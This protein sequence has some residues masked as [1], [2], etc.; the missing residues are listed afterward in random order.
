M[1]INQK[2]FKDCLDGSNHFLEKISKRTSEDQTHSIHLTALDT[3]DYDISYFKGL[4]LED[5]AA[6]ITAITADLIAKS[7]GLIL[8]DGSDNIIVSGGGRKN[9]FLLET[10]AEKIKLKQTNLPKLRAPQWPVT[11]KLIDDYGIDGDFVESQAF[12]YLSIRS[13]LKLPISFPSTTGVSK[14]CTGGVIVK[15]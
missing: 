8:F 5:G 3:K 6:T 13:Y 14:P 15:N 2:I 1:K 12:A 10:I 11:L 9:N 7:L 4:S